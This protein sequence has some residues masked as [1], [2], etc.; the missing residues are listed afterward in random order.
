[1]SKGLNWGIVSL[2]AVVMTVVGGISAFFIFMARRSAQMTG[3]APL[4]EAQ[5]PITTD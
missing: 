3:A 5:F 1:M 2:F 4:P